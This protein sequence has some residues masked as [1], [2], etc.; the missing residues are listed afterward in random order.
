VI[1]II[2]LVCCATHAD[3]AGEEQAAERGEAEDCTVPDS[4]MGRDCVANCDLAAEQCQKSCGGNPGNARYVEC[5]DCGRFK[6][7]CVC[8]CA[9]TTRRFF[10]G[11]LF[12]QTR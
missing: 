12:R 9:S 11:L 5:S 2:L 1:L 7:A 10:D 8:S 6:D 3:A 4:R